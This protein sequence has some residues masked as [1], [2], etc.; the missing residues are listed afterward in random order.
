MILLSPSAWNRSLME[1][2]LQ[3]AVNVCRNPFRLQLSAVANLVQ[4]HRS[5]LPLSNHRAKPIVPYNSFQD[6][7]RSS[8]SATYS[9][10]K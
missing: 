8:S 10:T 7:P 9:A 4:N 5:S 3:F 1:E 6:S 2:R